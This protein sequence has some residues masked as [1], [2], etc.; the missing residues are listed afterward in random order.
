[1]TQDVKQRLWAEVTARQDELVALCVEAISIASPNPPGHTTAIAGF[2]EDQLSTLSLDVDRF[3]PLPGA[4]NLVAST[5]AEGGRR[6]VFNSH[7]DT[8]PVAEGD[9]SHPPFSGDV[10]QGRIYGCGS[11]DMKAGLAVSLFLAKLVVEIDVELAGQ[12]I[13]SYSSDEETGGRWGTEWLLSNVDSVRG[14]A[15]VIGDQSGSDRV[16]VGEKGMCWLRVSTKGRSSHAAYGSGSSATRRLSEAL[17]VLYS[18]ED[19]STERAAEALDGAVTVNVGRIEGGVSP[20]LVAHQATAEVDIRI[21]PGLLVHDVVQELRWR[22]HAAGID[23]RVD[24][25]REMDPTSTD[26]KAEVVE[27][28]VQNCHE[29]LGRAPERAIRLGASDA[30]FFR[31]AD[32]PTIVHGPTAYNMGGPDEY[33]DIEELVQIAQVHVGIAADFLRVD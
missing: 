5:G 4:P 25:L 19:L 27:I 13:L 17:P 31:R 28:A 23:C 1:M 8:F 24:V 16:A 32:I 2:V 30:R 15:C 6:L 3:E 21:P 18:L 33:V 22:L 10:E 26:V 14:D 11:S 9:W 7:L 29:V 12:L 20:N